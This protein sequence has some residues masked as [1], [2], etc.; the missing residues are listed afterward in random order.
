MD[1]WDLIAVFLE[2]KF[3]V[4]GFEGFLLQIDQIDFL[5]E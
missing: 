2:K 3:S 5:G 1:I 4:D